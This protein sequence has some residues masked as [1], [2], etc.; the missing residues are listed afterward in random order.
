MTT[1]DLRLI[2]MRAVR[3]PITSIELAA[4]LNL[5]TAQIGNALLRLQTKSLVRLVGEVLLPHTN[6]KANRRIKQY[7]LVA[8]SEIKQKHKGRVILLTDERHW[9][10]AES[11]SGYGVHVGA[12]PLAVMG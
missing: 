5:T 9:R 2:H 10:R 3:K 6:R 8:K 7:A 4:A 11:V 1:A 12:S